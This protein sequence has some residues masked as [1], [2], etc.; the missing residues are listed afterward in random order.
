[1]QEKLV[2]DVIVKFPIIG[3]SVIDNNP[4]LGSV[5][6]PVPA[7]VIYLELNELELSLTSTSYFEK[8]YLYIQK[9]QID[10]SD[11]QG[12][13]PVMLARTEENER[14]AISFGQVHRLG[15][16]GEGRGFSS[17]SY[18]GGAIQQL[19]LLFDGYVS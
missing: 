4:D 2:R 6:L 10:N 19:D 18:L 17:I 15:Q 9:L 1:M 14:K 5:K 11:P 3:V 7:E 16:I 12:R 13:F 8:T